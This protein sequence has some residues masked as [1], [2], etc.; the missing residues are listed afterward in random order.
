MTEVLPSFS[1]VWFLDRWAT[2]Q[3]V[4]KENASSYRRIL[5]VVL[6]S[7]GVWFAQG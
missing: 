1:I 3:S 4:Q 7:G 6:L 5:F 2:I